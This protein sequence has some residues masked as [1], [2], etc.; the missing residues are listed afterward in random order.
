MVLNEP[1]LNWDALNSGRGVGSALGYLS[2][3]TRWSP[4]AVLAFAHLLGQLSATEP[5]LRRAGID[6]GMT[7]TRAEPHARVA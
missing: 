1:L 5:D 7:R 4:G 6:G 3:S 2:S